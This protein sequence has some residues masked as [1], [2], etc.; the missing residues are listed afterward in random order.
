MPVFLLRMG[1]RDSHLAPVLTTTVVHT[2]CLITQAMF[3]QSSGAMGS[4]RIVQ[5]RNEDGT[6]SVSELNHS[7][8]LWPTH[9]QL[10]RHHHR[11]TA[12]S[13]PVRFCGL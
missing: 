4:D 12:D 8:T 7:L 6:I 9:P 3:S 5:R 11:G 2:H 1:A 13:E 10:A